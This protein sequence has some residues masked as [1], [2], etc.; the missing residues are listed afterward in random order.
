MGQ[1]LKPNRLYPYLII[2][3]G[4][5]ARHFIHYFYLQDIPCRQW[6]CRL[7][8][9]LSDFLPQVHKAIVCLPDDVIQDFIY[10]QQNVNP[11]LIWI[12]CSGALS[13]PQAEAAHPLMTFS[14][15]L[16]SRSVYE[17]IWFVTEEGRSSFSDLF[18]EL[19]NPSRA[20][21]A[22]QKPLY[23][24]WATM[25]GNFTTLLWQTYFNR[26]QNQF[27][28]P[29]TAAE[30]YLRAITEN[31]LNNTEPLTGPLARGDQVTIE[32]HR[33]AL[34]SDQFKNIYDSFV[35]FYTESSLEENPA[36]D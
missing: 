8:E 13:I 17:S 14:N 19:P 4:R 35:K 1:V 33:V 16:Y 15:E 34:V 36:N 26:L 24:S 28:L 25:A 7:A 9:P 23:H 31:L 27:N 20:I 21:P 6:Y 32:K 22:D 18:P 29:A 11:A 5:L 10:R 12:H 30:P 3:N 2:G